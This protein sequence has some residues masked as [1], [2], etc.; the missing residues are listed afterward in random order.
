M[1]N[2]EGPSSTPSTHTHTCTCTH[3]H[4]CAHTCWAGCG[5]MFLTPVQRSWRQVDPW[6]WP[7]LLVSANRKTLSQANIMAGWVRSHSGQSTCC[8]SVSKLSS[9]PQKPQKSP[10]SFSDVR[11][12]RT[13]T[14]ETGAS[15]GVCRPAALVCA[16]A[17]SKWFPIKVEGQDWQRSSGHAYSPLGECVHGH[18]HTQRGEW[19]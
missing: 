18:I 13:P 9:N 14:V 15:L 5:S 8:M 19:F 10:W 7:S 12:S 6:G 4:A 2:H 1:H 3:T 11:N 16:A 17:N